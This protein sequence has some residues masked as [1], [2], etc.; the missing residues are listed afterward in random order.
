METSNT[1]RTWFFLGR[2]VPYIFRDFR[3]S[4]Y[5]CQPSVVEHFMSHLC[6]PTMLGKVTKQYF[7]TGILHHVA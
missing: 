2:R 1:F 3:S 7:R 4:H 5:C 6:L